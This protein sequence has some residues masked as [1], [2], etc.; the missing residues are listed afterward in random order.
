MKLGTNE[1]YGED[2]LPTPTPNFDVQE[3]KHFPRTV[4]HQYCVAPYTF[5]LA[6]QV[7]SEK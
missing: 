3:K 2:I 7:D 4:S 5:H 1:V 6:I